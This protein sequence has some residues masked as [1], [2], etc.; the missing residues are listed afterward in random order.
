MAP[1]LLPSDVYIISDEAELKIQGNGNLSSNSTAENT[2][3]LSGGNGVTMKDNRTRNINGQ[4]KS[5]GTTRIRE[6]PT[7]QRPA[8]TQP[9][10]SEKRRVPSPAISATLERRSNRVNVN[11]Y[12]ER[13][14]QTLPHKL[15]I[16]KRL[17]EDVGSISS[18]SRLV[19]PLNL[20]MLCI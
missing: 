13:R 1:D 8:S 20:L 14:N 10:L 11:G 4:L 15:V 18:S 17:I 9:Y 2:K 19:H 7:G 3:P 5:N 16:D 6:Q 12:Q